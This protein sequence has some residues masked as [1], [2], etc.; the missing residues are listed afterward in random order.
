MEMPIVQDSIS[1]SVSTAVKIEPTNQS[2][3]VTKNAIEQLKNCFHDSYEDLFGLN[4]A[5]TLNLDLIIVSA[6]SILSL[7]G[8]YLSLKR[9]DAIK[10]K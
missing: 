6:I 1:N 5:Y 4:W 3:F 2:N 8:I 10:I 7:S 9:K